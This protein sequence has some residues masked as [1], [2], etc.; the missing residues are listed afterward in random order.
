MCKTGG[1]YQIAPEA[2]GKKFDLKSSYSDRKALQGYTRPVDQET[3][4][5]TDNATGQIV[6]TAYI[7]FAKGGWL[8]RNGWLP[9][10][11][12]GQGPLFGRSQCFPGDV[13]EQ[14]ASRQAIT[15]KIIN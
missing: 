15:R 1:V 3:Q 14:A 6:A 9:A 8:V 7:Y 5:Y 12:G 10:M 4:S 11:S 2:I 13:P